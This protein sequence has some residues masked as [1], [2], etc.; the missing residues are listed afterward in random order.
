M[1]NFRNKYR[2]F[3]SDSD[4]EQFNLEYKS[5]TEWFRGGSHIFGKMKLLSVVYI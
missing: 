2:Q 4:F 3:D 1:M 5:V